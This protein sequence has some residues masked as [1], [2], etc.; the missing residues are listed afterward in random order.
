MN[1]LKAI[2]GQRIALGRQGENLALTVKFSIAPWAETYGQGVAHLLYQR[3]GDEAPYP[4]AIEMNGTEVLWPVTDA[5]TFAA[6]YGKYELRYTVGEIL[7]KSAIGATYVWEAME[8]S[9]EPPETVKNW[10]DH[11]T[12]QEHKL[13]EA[14]TQTQENAE[15]AA[16]AADDAGAY[17]LSS[18]ASAGEAALAAQ[19]A[20]ASAAEAKEAALTAKGI[21]VTAKPG[22]LIRA[23]SVDENGKPTEWEP[24]PWG[25]A[26]GET[27]HPIP[28]KFLPDG[29]PYVEQGEMVELPIVGEWTGEAESKILNATAPIGLEVGESYVVNCDGTD[30]PVVAQEFDMDGFSSVFIGNNA[31]IGGEETVEPFAVIEIPGGVDGVYAQIM[32]FYGYT[33]ISI[34]SMGK[35]IHKIDPRCLPD[36][37]GGGGIFAVT[38]DIDTMTADAGSE[39]IRAAMM[40]G[41]TV[42]LNL[43]NGIYTLPCVGFSTT[44]AFF[45]ALNLGGTESEVVGALYFAVK[46]DGSIIT[47]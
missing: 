31:L 14:V 5:D 2:P 8:G 25:Y 24:V 11:M 34:K 7:A 20:A 4:V 43:G 1:I 36:D 9:T 22:Q 17:A 33:T 37:V 46:A 38:A 41:K 23:K 16:G 6:G 39:Q 44:S 10:L 27:I 45:V 29:V 19:N 3:N 28:G 30:Y 15:A 47:S 40:Q 13:V 18:A 32:L 26:E 35:T 12:E 21:N 42:F